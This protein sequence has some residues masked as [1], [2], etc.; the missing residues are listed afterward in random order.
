MRFILVV[1]LLV[2]FGVL[3]GVVYGEANLQLLV[4][5]PQVDGELALAELFDT[6]EIIRDE[7]G[8]PHIYASNSHDLFFAQ[9]FT[10][11][12]DRWWQMEWWRHSGH[13]RLGA[14]VGKDLLGQD[15]F[16]R[17][18]GA[19]HIVEREVTE[20]YSEEVISYLQAFA[21]G[22]NAYISSREQNE[23]ALEYNGLA[24]A[25]MNITI[26]A[27]TPADSLIWGKFMAFNQATNMDIELLLSA[28]SGQL[29]PEMLDQ[30]GPP[31]PYGEKP[32]ILA[33]ED[34]PITEASLSVTPKDTYGIQGIDTALAG[35]FELESI[36]PRA[37]MGSNNWVVN[38]T[39]SESGMPLLAN[40]P[41]LPI[42]MPSIW[43]EIGLHCQ[44]VSEAC[45]FDVTGFAFSSAPGVVIGHNARIAWGMTN[46][47]SDVQDLYLIRVNPNNPLQYEWDGEWRD[48]TTREETIRFADGSEPVT[49][50][51]R[52][53]HFG[54]IIN[55][56]QLDDEGQVMGFNNEDPLA[57]RWT[58]L[59]PGTISQAALL[60]NKAGNWREFREALRSWDTPSQNFIYADVEGNIGY[61]TPGR[62]P[63]RAE[64]HTG[65]MPVPGWTSDYEWREY[66]PFDSLPRILNPQRG[67]V[68]TA[69]QAL[70]PL[71]Y[72]DQLAAQL[73]EDANYHFSYYTA[74]GYRA[75]RI[76]ELI[77]QLAPHTVETFQAI[78]GDNKN[79]SATE[80]LPYLAQI[81]FEDVA[82]ADAR[83][84]LLDWD[85]QMHMDSPQAALYA[86]FWKSLVRHTYD[87]EFRDLHQATGNDNELWATY[88]LMTEPDN[89][90]WDDVTTQDVRETRDD[91]L[92][93][94]FSEAYSNTIFA[95]GN[96]RSAWR[97]GDLHT[98]TFVSVPLGLSGI[99]AVENVVNRGPV[100]TSGGGEIINA[101]NWSA[102]SE[103]FE[104]TNL[105][106][107]RMIVD[108]GN[109]DN[110]RTIH[111]TGQSGNPLSPHY[112][113]MIDT[114]RM[115]QY[116]PML[117]SREQVEAAGVNKLTLL[118][119]R[120]QRGIL[121]GD[122]G[123][124]VDEN[125]SASI[126]DLMGAIIIGIVLRKYR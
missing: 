15:I 77:V 114:W 121:R 88:Q 26:E 40:D 4:P 31:F 47:I 96:D 28:L 34:L 9:G 41:H 37:G 102:S 5:L 23:L 66:I 35:N 2:S 3:S 71:A 89:A 61:Q 110:S 50:V 85:Y 45:P 42:M 125:Y 55:D 33:D 109:F 116:H 119:Q 107:M 70:V 101:T 117:W 92:I 58:G 98:A 106:S 73:G 11:A 32:T 115:I 56:N 27:W 18:L 108:V 13:G 25:G 1:F 64:G 44:P 52:E 62:L 24:L 87:D 83:D 72:Y 76:N 12:Q 60:L 54:P 104:V 48:M 126:F 86:E 14:L 93:G 122:F 8:I 29:S 7:W 36:W 95:L 46:V 67:Y 68:A 65:I 124:S 79:I 6:V 22:V 69:N 91:I 80:I 118:P 111:T 100:A 49:I 20:V 43:Y 53:T 39:M 103:D 99:T 78:Q 105:P 75:Q 120:T 74:Y 82:L 97:W 19:S 57:L 84:W 10:Q 30:Y 113:D 81:A 94:A 17:T 16:T 21:D 112:S 123:R 90:W 63:I 59:E 38:G 51:V